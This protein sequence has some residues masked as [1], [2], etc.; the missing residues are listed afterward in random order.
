MNVLTDMA[1]DARRPLAARAYPVA[2]W[3]LIGLAA[4]LAVYPVLR[5]FA[6]VQVSYNEGWN[7]YWQMRAAE[8]LPIYSGHPAAMFCNYPPLSFLIVGSL[9]SLGIDMMLA[10]RLLSLASLL[11]AA[12]SCGFVVR[13]FGGD[14]NDALLAAAAL[15]LPF[16]VFY[17][18]YVGSNDP[19]LL[20]MAFGLAALAVHCGGALTV[21]RSVVV[22]ALLVACVFT[23]HN[24]LA[25]PAAIAIDTLWRAD[26]R[27]RIAFLAAG[28]GLSLTALGLILAGEGQAF[29]TQMLS[30]REWSGSRA[31]DMSREMLLLNLAPLF[32]TIAAILLLRRPWARLIG[33]Y[34]GLGLVIA[35]YFSGGA[36]TGE[37][38][39]FDVVVALAIA[40]G[41]AAAACRRAGLRPEFVLAV[42]AAASAAPVLAAPRVALFDLEGFAGGLQAAEREFAADAAFVAAQPGPAL[43]ESLMLCLAAGKDPEVDPF[44]A[45]QATRTGTLP[46][47]A[48]TAP[49]V[50]QHY[51]VIQIRSPRG[52]SA[53]RFRNFGLETY[54]AVAERYRV[55]RKSGMGTFSVPAPR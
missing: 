8:G 47:D 16:L 50:A 37:N 27:A 38:I 29:V 6:E 46:A 21:K 49:I 22:A 42:V 30:P 2:A 51:G 17:G 20:G 18:P 48:V 11:F 19:Q 24:L 39:W 1:I 53:D 44:N 5:V 34:L 7:L 9:G 41:L 28:I 23:K 45:Y 26:K 43:C 31:F 35:V 10:A 25:L 4:L 52:T 55:V 40:S 13:K 36:G 33:I 15:L 3:A 54:D 12:W 32:V 14:L